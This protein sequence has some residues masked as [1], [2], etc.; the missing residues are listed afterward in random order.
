MPPHVTYSSAAQPIS[1]STVRCT[2]QRSPRAASRRTPS[3]YATAS[4]ATTATHSTS[5]V[6]WVT[7]RPRVSAGGSGSPVSS[8]AG[9]GSAAGS[10]GT[11]LAVRERATPAPRASAIRTTSAPTSRQ[12]PEVSRSS[13]SSRCRRCHQPA[14]PRARSTPI[15]SSR[16][17]PYRLARPSS[18]PTRAH[19]FAAPDA[20][21][22][23]KPQPATTEYRRATAPT[24]RPSPPRRPSQARATSPPAQAQ[25]P[26]RCSHHDDTTSSW[27][28]APEEWPVRARGTSAT[29]P[30]AAAVPAPTGPRT[31]DA[32]TATTA[33][34]P[35]SMATWRPIEISETYCHRAGPKPGSVSGSITTS[36]APSTRTAT[37][38]S[39][40]TTAATLPRERAR[41]HAGWSGATSAAAASSPPIA[42]AAEP[43]CT[44]RATG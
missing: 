24:C 1:Q 19:A 39:A 15:L 29:T 41:G 43:S 36:A 25:T 30:R 13:R 35:I 14:A 27:L 11:G 2:G 31:A 38:A 20:A 18:P 42:T 28:A 8:S 10:S 37:P 22:R 32:S 34:I 33:T 6:V 12:K 4:A 7:S 16:S 40:H 23:A 3:R 5:G 44:A 26:A 17:T 21:T 9:V